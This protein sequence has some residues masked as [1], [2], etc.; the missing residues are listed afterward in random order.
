PTQ[1]TSPTTISF[2]TLFSDISNNRLL[3]CPSPLVG[4]SQLMSIPKGTEILHFPSF[5][6]YINIRYL[7]YARWI[8]RFRNL[9]ITG[10]SRLPEAY[11]R[12]SRLSSPL[13]AKASTMCASL[14]DHTTPSSLST[15]KCHT[16]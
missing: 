14:L 8:S 16:I 4:Q 12:L 9:R 10:Y 5:A 6:S 1:V 15:A 13:T 7:A 11:R 2:P 3:P